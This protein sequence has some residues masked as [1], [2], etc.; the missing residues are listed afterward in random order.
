VLALR[1]DV[2]LGEA[3][4]LTDGLDVTWKRFL[5]DVAEGL[6][7]PEPKSSVPYGVAF[8]TAFA[9]EYGYRFLRRRARV[10]TRPLLSRQ[11][12]HVLGRDQDFSNRK[13]QETLGWA[14]LVSYQDGLGATIKWLREEYLI[15]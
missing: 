10:N 3:F 12:V 13:A 9:L 4:N 11:A 14:P 5:G 8:G 6:G 2:G 7:Y 1:N 15:S